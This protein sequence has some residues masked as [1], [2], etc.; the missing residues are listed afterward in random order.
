MDGSNDMELPGDDQQIL[1]KDKSR[2]SLYD[3]AALP[4][5]PPQ[6]RKRRFKKA[7]RNHHGSIGTAPSAAGSHGSVT[8]MKNSLTNIGMDESVYIFPENPMSQSLSASF[9]GSKTPFSSSK[10]KHEKQRIH[11]SAS[12]YANLSWNLENISN[13]F[14]SFASFEPL[15][16]STLKRGDRQSGSMNRRPS[17]ESF[18]STTSSGTVQETGDAHYEWDDYRDPPSLSEIMPTIVP[19]DDASTSSILDSTIIDE[20]FQSQIPFDDD[21]GSTLHECQQSYFQVR[22]IMN[23]YDPMAQEH[24][25]VRRALRISA[26]EN[27]KKLTAIVKALPRN[28]NMDQ[29]NEVDILQKDWKATLEQLGSADEDEVDP[30]E[31]M[32][33]DESTVNEI[34]I[35]LAEMKAALKQLLISDVEKMTIA[36]L[37]GFI[38]ERKQIWDNLMYRKSSLKALAEQPGNRYNNG[39]LVTLLNIVDQSLYTIGDSTLQLEESM[40][41]YHSMGN[42][43]ESL[44]TLK[45]KLGSNEVIG[46]KTAEGI[47]M[48][49]ELCQERMDALETVCN[50]LT[51]QLGDLAA[52]NGNRKPGKQ[53]K[54]WKEL[55]QYKNSLKQLKE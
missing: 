31:Q 26:K 41:K 35:Q 7:I 4:P 46:S 16:T 24:K 36:D 50:G 10:R 40:T 3:P 45:G 19:L 42:L 14:H 55:N 54:F 32:E 34:K 25:D 8:I 51:T 1:R 21:I 53:A 52:L 33:I 28:L 20:D 6:Q 48:E 12:D 44:E 43:A 13:S 22:R 37:E 15:M 30:D 49:L 39:E 29:I 2:Q 27:V 11:R 47:K 9:F 17:V 38:A 18:A 5:I 23:D